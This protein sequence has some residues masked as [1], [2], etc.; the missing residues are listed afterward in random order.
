MWG[1]LLG[2]ALSPDTREGRA[3]V[4]CHFAYVMAVPGLYDQAVNNWR[5]TNPD[6]PLLSP[7]SAMITIA[8]FSTQEVLSPNFGRDKVLHHLIHNWIPRE[9]VAHAYYYSHHYL[10]QHLQS[11]DRYCVDNT[12]I[13]D[14]HIDALMTQEEPKAYPPWDGWYHPTQHDL[15][16]IHVLIR[17]EEEQ[18]MITRDNPLLIAVGEELAP[19]VFSVLYPLAVPYQPSSSMPIGNRNMEAPAE[20][21]ADTCTE[22]TSL[23]Q[24]HVEGLTAL[25]MGETTQETPDV[26]MSTT[27]VGAGEESSAMLMDVPT[28]GAAPT[29]PVE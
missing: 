16:R 4:M 25:T 24:T 13:N 7:A 6:Q 5:A 23:A 2:R 27:A 8:R 15:V 29:A 19:H 20:T 17:H 22:E 28:G 21:S 10:H 3:I 18:W 26:V 12:L 9:W 1:Y 11:G 14:K